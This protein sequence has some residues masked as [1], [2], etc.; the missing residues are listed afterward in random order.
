MWFRPLSRER[1]E[2]EERGKGKKRASG[3]TPGGKKNCGFSEVIGTG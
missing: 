2:R 3:Y 1:E